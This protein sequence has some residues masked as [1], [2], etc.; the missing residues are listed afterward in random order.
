MRDSRRSGGQS[1]AASYGGL[2]AVLA[3]T[4][5]EQL[6]RAVRW[7]VFWPAP[8]ER[9]TASIDALRRQALPEA[10]ARVLRALSTAYALPKTITE[11]AAEYAM[12]VRRNRD[13]RLALEDTGDSQLDLPADLRRDI[14]RLG[15]GRVLLQ[16]EVWRRRTFC[17]L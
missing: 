4:K 1:G 8:H 5:P 6:L 2:D 13:L 14:V 16:E 10:P 9:W 3:W 15:D 17:D 11:A 12:R 7:S